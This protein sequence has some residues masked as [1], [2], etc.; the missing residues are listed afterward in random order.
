MNREEKLWAKAR[1][2]MTHWKLPNDFCIT[3]EKGLNGYTRA[4][5]G[6][7]IASPFPTAYNDRRNHLKLAFRQQD[8][9]GWDNLIKGRMGRQWIEYVKQ[10]IHNENIKLK[11]SDWAPKMIQ[12]LWDHMLRLWQYRNDELHENNKKKV[13]QFKVEAMDRDIKRLEVRI[14]D[15]RHKLRTFQEEHMQRVEHVKTLQHNSRKC[16]AA[17]AKMYL[18]EAENI[19]ET[20]IRLMDQYLQG[21]SGVG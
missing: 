14:E 5:S 13:A 6:G 12:A 1:K 17:L 10:H 2:V 4:P 9:I 7:A 18:D 20:D 21:R 15:L 11:A 8:K 19:I 3:M 16:W